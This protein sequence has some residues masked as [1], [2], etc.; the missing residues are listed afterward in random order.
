MPGRAQPRTRRSASALRDL[1]SPPIAGDAPFTKTTNW[2]VSQMTPAEELDLIEGSH[3][4]KWA[5]DSNLDPDDHYEAGYVQGIPRLGIPEMRHVDAQG[6]EVYADATSYPTRL[7]LSASFDRAAIQ[8]FGQILGQDGKNLDLDLIYSPQ[9]DIAYT[10]SWRRNMTAYSEDAYLASQFT[11]TEINAIQS[12]GLL[13]QVKHV[14]VYTGQNQD[15]PTEVGEQAIR[16]LYL[17][18]AQAA[19]QQAGVSSLMCSYATF[20]IVGYQDKADYSCS[21]SGL[22][23]G[24]VR[25]DWGFKGWVTTDYLA[26]KATSDLLAGTDQEFLTKWFADGKLLPLIDP[27]SPSFNQAYADAAKNAVTRIVYQYERFGLLDND[28]IPAEFRSKVPQHGDVDSYDNSIHIDKQKGIRTA[29]DLAEK[30][31]VLLKNDGNALPLGKRTSVVT[32]GQSATLLPASPGGE[33]SFG[34]GDRVAISPTDAMQAKAGTKV[35]NVPGID[36]WGSPVPAAQLSQDSAGTQPGL[37][38]TQTATDGTVTTTV[39]TVIDGNQK[40]L[41]KGNSYTWSGYVDVPAGGTY[42][43]LVQRPYGTDTGNRDAYNDGVRNVEQTAAPAGFPDI[44]PTPPGYAPIEPALTLDGAAIALVDPDNKLVANDYPPISTD[45]ANHTVAANG[46]YLGV[47]NRG[48]VVTL[49]AGPHQFTLSYT[50]KADLATDPA[51]RFAWANTQADYTAAEAAARTNDVSVIFADD[52][53]ALL[54]DGPSAEASV[55]RLTDAQTELINRTAAAA[56]AA[57][58]K[59][60]VVLNTGGAVQMPWVDN[61]DAI[62][63]M[64]YPGQEGGTATSNVLYGTADPSGKLTISFPRDSAHTLFSDHPERSIGTQEPDETAVSY[65]RTEGLATGYRWFT[66]PSQ[67]VNGYKPLYAF[68]HGLSYTS[69][70][71]SDLVTTPTPDGGADVKFTITNTGHRAG[72]ESAQIYIGPSAALPDHVQQT[73]LRLVQFGKVDLSAGAKKKLSLHIDPAQFA[74]YDVQVPGW[75]QGTGNRQLWVG[76][77]SDDLKLTGSITVTA[78]SSSVNLTASANDEVYGSK[79][80]LTLTATVTA[81]TGTPTGTVEF[82]SGDTSLGTAPVTDGKATFQLLD[83]TPAGT[84]RITAH[85]GGVAPIPAADSNTVEVTV[86]QAT[87][88]TTLFAIGTNSARHRC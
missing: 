9:T 55:A 77:A 30:S 79:K 27:A 64:W 88:T 43:L 25:G 47:K 7:G 63:E 21:N 12:T 16:E 65:K 34:F 86:K 13:A 54:N 26:A 62:L 20:Q 69:F 22:L 17:A 5:A 41:V 8:Q 61:V 31:A 83:N 52:S 72:S 87:S 45:P 44:Q 85:Y 4:N 58:K 10:P 6:V 78:P 2:L 67:N 3:A 1:L 14:G 32:L 74:S 23:N 42:R 15:K 49:Q 48:Q 60:V 75:V 29:L 36:I 81:S 76:A 71:Y 50:P 82:R 18:T 11:S 40:G 70:T 73:A 56:H 19:V 33:R 80:H 57:G 37:V 84:L 66:D 46:Q 51:L 68:G 24:I 53:N 38:R 35:T 59:V 28:H 39:D